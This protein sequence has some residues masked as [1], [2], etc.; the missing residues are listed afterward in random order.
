MTRCK[1]L[2][3]LPLL[4]LVLTSCTRDPKIL[5]Q[6]YLDNGNKFFAKGKFKDAVIMYRNA[7]A[8]DKLFGEGYYRLAL[9]D[10]KLGALSDAVHAL[11]RAVEL[12]PNNTDAETKLAD[13]YMLA[14]A[15]DHKNSVPL[16]K[17]A[18]ELADKLLAQNPSSFDGHRLRGQL[19]LMPANR[20]IP[21]AVKEFAAANQTNPLQ[22]DLCV[23]Y[24]GALVLNNQFPEAEKLAQDL[25]AK[26]K[27]YGPM[28]D[29]LYVQYRRLNRLDDAERV[30]KLKTVNN[31]RNTNYLLQLAAY[32]Y[33]AKRRDDMEQVMHKIADQK[34]FPDG[35]LLAGDFF[36][37]QLR[38]FDRASQ[39]YEAGIKAFPKDKAVY[40]K[41]MVELY[42]A[43]GKNNDA[44]QLLA[45]ILKDNAKDNDAIAMR[46][47]L[48]VTTGNRDQINMAAN[49]L[50]TLVTKSPTNH[51][52]R[53]NLAKALVAKGEAAQAQIQLEEA[54]KLRPDFVAAHEL[55]A[56]LYLSKADSAQA[57]KAANDLIALSPNDLPAHLV[58]SSALINLKDQERAHKE[59][60]MILKAYP[61]NAD[62]RYQVGVLAWQEKDYKKAEQVFGDLYK[63]NPKDPRGLLGITETLASENRIND[64]IA[65]LEKASQAE[66]ERMDLKLGLANLYTRGEK[67]DRAIDIYKSL[68]DKQPKSADLLYKLAE[69][70]RREGDINLAID[71]FRRASE[72]APNSTAPLIQLGLL[73]DGTDRGD[74][75]QPIYEQILKIDPSD[76]VALNNLAYI[77]AEQ[78][79]DLESALS[80]AQK[81]RQKA[82]KSPQ[83]A[84]T[85]GWIYIR[86][87]LSDEAIRI[88][89]DVVVQEPDNPAF[90]YHYGMALLQKGDRVSAKHELDLAMKN[91]PSK[92]DKVKIQ[93]LLQNL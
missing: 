34:A 49:D 47:A 25:I 14:S 51:L 79:N 27:T 78:G 46:A 55:L 10:L 44:N 70:Y 60:D 69:A 73:M 6:R 90:H 58:R 15:Q 18:G 13:L 50:Q 37:F 84:D 63:S 62:A 91:N 3:F 68:V 93:N 31:P 43:T 20:D 65:Q 5:A 39:E 38:E 4:L 9:A 85:L 87:N 22:P 33:Q 11:M 71:N 52:L 77:K 30:L 32:Y 86:K 53:Y 92:G 57:L 74:Q 88:F 83:I 61:Q 67:Y 56:R 29:Y 41:R 12:Q 17:D 89:K 36:F 42:A 7:L 54:I 28:Y 82:P 76:P 21:A 8:K 66:P 72:S 59:L 48:M 1:Y 81:A 75:A 64:A 80:M 19:A 2:R 45:T 26:E 40:Q 16:A 24:F 23:S 35:R